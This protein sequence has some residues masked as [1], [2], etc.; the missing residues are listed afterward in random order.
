MPR[1]TFHREKSLAE[2]QQQGFGGHTLCAK[3]NN[4]TGAWYVAAFVHWCVASG[5]LLKQTRGRERFTV[6]DIYPLRIVKQIVAMFCSLRGPELVQAPPALK[7]LLL[8]DP[9]L[10]GGV[11][12]D[13]DEITG[14]TGRRSPA[15]WRRVVSR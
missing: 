5:E 9:N 14:E 1:C 10:V 2:H 7:T 11:D 4:D 12:E 15:V 8:S 6:K 3:C 13:C